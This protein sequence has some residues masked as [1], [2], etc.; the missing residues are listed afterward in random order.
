M[1]YRAFEHTTDLRADG[2]RWYI[3]LEQKDGF[4]Y[5]PDGGTMPEEV[6]RELARKWNE[7]RAVFKTKEP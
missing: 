4:H 3:A 7:G 5:L 6:A 2:N 1:R